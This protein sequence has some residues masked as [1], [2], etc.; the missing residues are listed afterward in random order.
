MTPEGERIELFED[1]ALNLTFT[2]DD[3]RTD[4]VAARH[5]RPVSTPIAFHHVHLYLPGEAHVEA[6]AWY[7]RMFGGIAGKR[8]QY[9]AVDLPGI[10]LNFSGGRSTAP[11]KGRMLDHI[12][13]EVRDLEPFCKR[14]ETMGVRFDSPYAKGSDGVAR[15]VITDPWGTTIELSEGLR[16]F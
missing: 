5:N 8:S 13:F 6:K 11:T 9:D 7:A 14:L 3:G 10:N 1:A 16:G 4:A 2:A 12:G 15:A